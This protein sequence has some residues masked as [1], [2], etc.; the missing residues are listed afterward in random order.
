MSGTGE[1]T[2]EDRYYTQQYKFF[3]DRFGVPFMQRHLI[4]RPHTEAW[5]I[6]PG[7]PEYGPAAR[8]PGGPAPRPPGYVVDAYPPPAHLNPG[9]F[10]A[11]GPQAHGAPPPNPYGAAPGA[12]RYY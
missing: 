5:T 4:P 12:G 10:G 3:E 1:R 2:A 11:T 7:T 9:L 6:K 8:P